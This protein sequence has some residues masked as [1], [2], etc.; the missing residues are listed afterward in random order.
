MLGTKFPDSK[1]PV[2]H[3]VWPHLMGPCW[4]VL[5]KEMAA[6]ICCRPVQ[7]TSLNLAVDSARHGVV[8]NLQVRINT[9]LP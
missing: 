6:L 9:E 7:A 3:R 5:R 2:G 8:I 1:G 4:K